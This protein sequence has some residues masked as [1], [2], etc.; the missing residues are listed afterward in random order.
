M[1]QTLGDSA[2][3]SE[4]RVTLAWEAATGAP[5]AHSSPCLYSSNE[6]GDEYLMHAAA[7]EK[8]RT[9][10]RTITLYEFLDR[11]IVNNSYDV[12]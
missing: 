2:G 1:W 8:L 3:F 6:Q 12:I 9:P 5:A 10:S 7:A 11:R 4:L